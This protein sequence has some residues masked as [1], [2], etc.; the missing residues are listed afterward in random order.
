MCGIQFDEHTLFARVGFFYLIVRL[1]AVS[2]SHWLIG[3]T[4]STPLRHIH[5]A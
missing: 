3:V 2:A 1:K 4:F 5:V